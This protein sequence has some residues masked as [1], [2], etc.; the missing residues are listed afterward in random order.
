MAKPF[1]K[2]PGGKQKLLPQLKALLP[3]DWKSRRYV[4]PFLGGGALFFEL[5]PK[6]AFLAD[7]NADLMLTYFAVRN[8]SDLV[9]RE[10]RILKERHNEMHYYQL[11]R[12]YNEPSDLH[13]GASDHVCVA[14]RA[15]WFIYL[16]KTCFNGLYRVNKDGE[17]NVPYGKYEDPLIVDP[18]TLFEAQEALNPKDLPPQRKEDHYNVTRAEAVTILRTHTG[19]ALGLGGFTVWEAEE[20]GV[21]GDFFYF[22]PPYLPVSEQG[23]FTSYTQDGFSFADHARLAALFVTLNKRG[24]KLMLSN[25]DHPDIVGLYSG[26]KVNRVTAARSINSDGGGRGAVS[27]IVVC[28]Y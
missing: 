10:L 25:C 16:N 2:W 15:A 3:S 5:Q 22:D 20:Y 19:L 21:E 23:N 28:N 8:F 17:F 26:F 1:L 14:Q 18:V 27:E 9:L 6:H 24:C 11:R 4:E 12:R 7:A 13:A